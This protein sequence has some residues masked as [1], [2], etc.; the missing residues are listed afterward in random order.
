MAKDPEKKKGSLTADAYEAEDVLAGA[1]PWSPTETKL[2][3]WSFVAALIALVLFGALI[4][5][6]VLK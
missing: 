6:Y 5:I 2:V 1:E 4:N 3:V